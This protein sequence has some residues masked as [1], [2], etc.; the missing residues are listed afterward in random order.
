M[1]LLKATFKY[2]CACTLALVA[3]LA[4]AQYRPRDESVGTPSI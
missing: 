4:N 3:C 2:G 1:S